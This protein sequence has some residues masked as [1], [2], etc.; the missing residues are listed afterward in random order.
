M[1]KLASLLCLLSFLVAAPVRATIDAL[2]N[3]PAATLLLPYFAIDLLNP[4]ER[5]LA[6]IGNV[7]GNE[8]LAHAV[9]WTDRGVPTFS[10]D[11]RLAAHDVAE[12]DLRAI[13]VNGVLP[14][15]NPGG[16][17]SCTA[18]LPPP[19][20]SAAT[21][22]ALRNAHR[23]QASALLGGNC[24]GAVHGDNLARGYLTLDVVN[25]CTSS[26]TFPAT[27]GYFID[28]GTG[29]ARND[30]LLFG[31]YA[32]YDSFLGTAQG[33]AL[34]AI[35][36]SASDPATDGT[37]NQVCLGFPCP[38]TPFTPVPDYTFY[39]R[40]I[41]S[42]ADNREGLPQSW[43]G[44][45][46]NDA[47]ASQTTALVWR[48]PG[49]VTPFPCG[50]PPPGL[51]T[52]EVVAIDEQEHPAQSCPIPAVIPTL[53]YATQALELNDPS[54]I[55]VPFK[56]GFVFYKLRLTQANG[57]LET[58]NQS[59]VTH[60]LR[61]QWA[62]SVP[63]LPPSI[64][65]GQL[66]AWPI[67]PIYDPTLGQESFQLSC[68]V[69][70][71]G[72]DNDNDTQT[73][74]P[75]DPGCASPSF[76]T[77]SPECSDGIDNDGDGFIDMAD[78]S[79]SSP[80][81]TSELFP[82][83]TQ[84]NDR[85]DNDGDG[86]IDYPNDPGC[87]SSSSNN[88][89]PQCNNGIND[90]GDGLID[91]A[92]PGCA[93]PSSDNESPACNDGQD[94]DGDSLADMTDPGCA[95]PSSDNESPECDDGQDND[96]DSLI[97][98]ADSG[99]SSP[100]DNSEY[101]PQCSD[102]ID[103]DGDTLTDYPNDPG[104]AS[105]D[106]DNE[107]PSCNDGVDNDGDTLI[108][109]LDPGC[110]SP[111]D[112]SEWTWQCSDGKDNDGD[113]KIDWPNDPGCDNIFDDSEV[114]PQCKDGIDNDGNGLIDWPNDPSCSSPNDSFELPD[115]QDGVDNDF[116]G[117]VDYPNDP[118]CASPNDYNELGGTTTRQCSDNIDNDGDGRTDYPSDSGCASRGD[119]VE[120]RAGDTLAPSAP[121]TPFVAP[122]PIPSLSQLGLLM[123]TA[124]LALMG[125]FGF[126]R[127]A[128][129]D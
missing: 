62:A 71:D 52:Q 18:S 124:L 70:N 116:D 9:L 33:D 2:D 59:F 125:M 12:I 14:Q 102:G 36:A 49:A 51:T 7:S 68:P 25:Q 34:V 89:S 126:R 94:N 110:F 26:S 112:D 45:Y 24:G 122:A 29:I 109:M 17:V 23:G 46:Q 83:T 41:G 35:E 40:V 96:G 121:P 74:Y 60:V 87:A 13:F 104:C 101:V 5:T 123:A 92:D 22:T 65:T 19:T 20:L 84:C 72:L 48:D 128:M 37:D 55:Y 98:T 30:N 63:L 66:P 57:D 105:A 4:N 90:D 56:G 78:P 113:G 108:D 103:N 11:L 39:R 42:A 79:C 8:I 114:D 99:C 73:D 32:T 16:F 43:F 82:I 77:E 10:F 80:F 69:C 107:I 117:L 58:R 47:P 93:S 15:T 127:S 64:E 129:K 76:F 6:R 50:S 3:V 28:G 75:N 97:D 81:D 53:P 119:D 120:F 38:P 44:Y 21:L 118:G 88:E 31:E 54:Q 91:M 100:S 95:S 61:R 86:L 67:A 1:K 106:S 111:S 85:I 27:A 115:C